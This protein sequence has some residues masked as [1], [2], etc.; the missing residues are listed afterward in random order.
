VSQFIKSTTGFFN[1]EQIKYVEPESDGT[2]RFYWDA[3]NYQVID[4][5]STLGDA[6]DGCST[7]LRSF[8]PLA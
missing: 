2:A 7:L 8:D 5:G 4:F 3:T 1:L 6:Q